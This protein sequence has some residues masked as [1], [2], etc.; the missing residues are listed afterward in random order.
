MRRSTTGS[1]R[2]DIKEY[3]ALV[4]AGR[5]ARPHLTY[6]KDWGGPVS[7]HADGSVLAL[8]LLQGQEE[9]PRPGSAH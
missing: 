2:G 9:E 4:H 5:H 1:A 3:R 6:N 7:V 8:R